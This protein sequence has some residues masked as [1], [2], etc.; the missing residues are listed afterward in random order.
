MFGKFLF[1]LV[2][3]IFLVWMRGENV[4]ESIFFYMIVG[5]FGWGFSWVYD[6]YKLGEVYVVL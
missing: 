1:L 3:L 6:L 5:K 2:F 4:L